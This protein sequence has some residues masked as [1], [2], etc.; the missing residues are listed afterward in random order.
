M[1]VTLLELNIDA[2]AIQAIVVANAGNKVT[3]VKAWNKETYKVELD[4][5]DLSHLLSGI[6]ENEDFIIS[7]TDLGVNVINGLW[8]IE[9]YSDEIAGAESSQVGTVVNLV[10]YHECLVDKAVSVVVKNCKVVKSSCGKDDSLL[11]ASTL[12]ESINDTILFELIDSTR[13][14]LF[15]LDE[16]CEVCDTCPEYATSLSHIGFS[17]KTVDNIIVKT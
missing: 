17:Y 4:A 6:N 3:K 9:F 5:V 8:I 12:L 1:I 11:F 15:T 10:P 7:S 16:L 14:I 13:Q 2:T